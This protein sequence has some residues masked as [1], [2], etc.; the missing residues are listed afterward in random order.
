LPVP[1]GEGPA[2]HDLNRWLRAGRESGRVEDRLEG[3]S[4]R[5]GVGPHRPGLGIR[6]CEIDR[7][8]GQAT[9]KDPKTIIDLAS[10]EDFDDHFD[11]VWTEEPER[12][13][14]VSQWN[15]LTGAALP[16]RSPPGSHHVE[17]TVVERQIG[18]L[19]GESEGI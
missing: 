13:G 6:D 3:A 11:V 1:S 18:D 15:D 17:A 16:R 14:V 5:V 19:S 7:H 9:G 4:L 12:A 10:V 2:I 8:I